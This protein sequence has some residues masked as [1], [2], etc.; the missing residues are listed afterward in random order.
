[1]WSVAFSTV[2]Q[3]LDADDD[4]NLGFS[5][6]LNEFEHTVA[7]YYMMV[8]M[9]HLKDEP[10]LP[11]FFEALLP[12]AKETMEDRAEQW[13]HDLERGV[14]KDLEAKANAGTQ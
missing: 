4:E 5:E 9:K 3:Y 14:G 2:S 11:D 10:P 13:I 7:R 8:V 6:T 12:V 1:M